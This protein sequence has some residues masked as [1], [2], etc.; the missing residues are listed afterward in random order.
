MNIFS[1][2]EMTL[3]AVAND[4]FISNDIEY[5]PEHLIK[6]VSVNVSAH[7]INAMIQKCVAILK[8]FNFYSG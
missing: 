4:F 5:D 6:D 2:P 8:V 3:L 7:L 1:I